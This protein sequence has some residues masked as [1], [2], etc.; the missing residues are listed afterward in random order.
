LLL[1][2]LACAPAT[3]EEVSFRGKT[4]IMIIGNAAGG[5]TDTSGRVIASFLDKRL[6]GSPT[7]IV[8]NMPGADGMTAT[9][10]FVQQ[11][12]PDG[13]TIMMESS[14]TADPLQYRKPQAH[15]D[16]T[17][18][19]VVGGIGRGGTML[20][21]NPEAEKRL[22]DK[23]QRPV[24]M[25]TLG[26]VPRSGMQ[27]TAWG[28][29]FLDWNAR[30]VVGY[31]GTNELMIALERG[32][33]D[34]TATANLFLTQKL[35]ATGKFKI[36]AQSG[37]PDNGIFVPR[38]DFGDAPVMATL[39]KDKLNDALAKKAF[40]FW[41]SIVSIDK[42]LALPPKTPKPVLAAYRKAFIQA[43]ED[44]AFVERGKKMS[45]EFV[46][47]SSAEVEK[48]IHTLHET[49]PE[50]MDYIAN[51]LRQQGLQVDTAKQEKPKR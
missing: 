15:Y 38:P 7:I 33:I 20:I 13:T 22:H 50:A 1:G 42:W 48:L 35:I 9:N 25:G 14:T 40:D 46:P 12:A 47:M 2:L 10:Y 51:M 49:P 34:M 8:R 4:I 36:L 5:G 45:E 18:F 6:P 19:G 27:M 11:V 24:I 17:T 23:S 44:P 26:G 41:S 21:I 16:P 3:A 37:L 29:R 39:L 31:R 43:T 32:E 30:W 28:I